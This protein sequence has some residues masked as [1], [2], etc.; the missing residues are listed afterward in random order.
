MGGA[1]VAASQL[2]LSQ[3]AGLGLRGVKMSVRMDVVS[4]SLARSARDSQFFAKVHRLDSSRSQ[5]WAHRRGRRRLASWHD[6]FLSV[7]PTL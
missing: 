6:Y 2:P 7:S 4:L 3:Q 5:C 1:C